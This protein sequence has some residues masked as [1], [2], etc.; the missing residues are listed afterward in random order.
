MTNVLTNTL[1]DLRTGDDERILFSIFAD[2]P[3]FES[4]VW[5]NLLDRI[6]LASRVRLVT[7]GAVTS[8]Q[9]TVTKDDFTRFQKG[10]VA[11]KDVLR[12]IQSTKIMPRAVKILT[13]SNI[14]LLFPSIT[15]DLDGTVFLLLI[16]YAE[17]S[18]LLSVIERT[19]EDDNHNGNDDRETFYEIDLRGFTEARRVV[20]TGFGS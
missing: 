6:R 14:D 8:N 13:D 3:V 7:S 19:D 1:Q 20:A 9:N 2:L 10:E 12:K 5:S 4:F 15:N 16:Q 11:D 18:I 17:W